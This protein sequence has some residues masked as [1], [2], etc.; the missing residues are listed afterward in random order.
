LVRYA[1]L[2]SIHYY[3][4]EPVVVSDLV[5]AQLIGGRYFLESVIGEGG[6]ASVWRALDQTLNRPV[7]I[8]FLYLRDTRKREAAVTSFLREARIAAAIRHRNVVDILD[9]GTLEDGVPFMVMELLEGETV[10]D[11]ISRMDRFS[12]EEVLTISARVLQ[13]LAAVHDAGIVHRDLKPANVFLVR[14]RSGVY[15]K[16]LDFGISRN[17]EPESGRESP[18]TTK[19]GHMVGTPEYMSCE[20]ARGLP[21][22]DKRTDLY[23]MGVI[24]YELLTG[25]LPFESEHSGDLIVQIM[26]ADPPKVCELRPEVGT[27]LSDL[28]TRA[29]QRDRE[30]RFTDAEEMY[31][32]ILS[33]AAAELGPGVAQA[34]SLPPSAFSAPKDNSSSVRIT[35]SNPTIVGV[36]VRIPQSVS[37]F[38]TAGRPGP[39]ERKSSSSRS[40]ALVVAGS[41]TAVVVMIGAAVGFAYLWQKPRTSASAP[42]YIVVKGVDETPAPQPPAENRAPSPTAV[43]DSKNSVSAKASK[44]GPRERDENERPSGSREERR[45]AIRAGQLATP[46]AKLAR[47]FAGQKAGI[48]QCFIQHASELDQ[49]ARLS[50]RIKLDSEGKV[51][52]AEVLPESTAGAP[53]GK[54]IAQATRAMK[55]D[56]PSE[57]ISFRVPL[58][59]HRER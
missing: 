20:Q 5:S 51:S 18:I 35:V 44:T 46:E 22:I 32:A 48:E 33:V 42:R 40:W 11:R 3:D 21:D 34:M 30:L 13:G 56:R 59:A 41:A 57:P 36:P 38:T 2:E 28:V 55:F 52:Q 10:E 6:M 50:V 58:T 25:R 49:A 37:P 54:C 17:V 26:T 24:L 43:N 39:E 53:L 9:F 8:K 4:L 7:A 1:E 12:V 16:L 19:D 29:M 27:P 23:S 14:D 31:R 15:P 45:P 47:A